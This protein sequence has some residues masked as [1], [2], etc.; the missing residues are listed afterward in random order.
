MDTP[1]KDSGVS[2]AQ[3]ASCGRRVAVKAEARD[4]A[5]VRVSARIGLWQEV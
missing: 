1:N 4:R 5:T 3:H 2:V